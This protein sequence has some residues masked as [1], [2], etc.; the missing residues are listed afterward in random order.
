MFLNGMILINN[1][2]GNVIINVQSANIIPKKIVNDEEPQDFDI[3]DVD[4]YTKEDYFSKAPRIRRIIQTK[5]INLSP[6]PKPTGEDKM[7][8][9]LTIG[10]MLTMGVISLVMLINLS[11]S[12]ILE[13]TGISIVVPVPLTV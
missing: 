10:P 7:P 2:Q 1:P 8:L 3:K 13:F 9:I 6:P 11:L 12:T 4:L 5:M